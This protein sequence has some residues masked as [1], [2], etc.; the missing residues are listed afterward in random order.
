MGQN[1]VGFNYTLHKYLLK[2]NN[3]GTRTTFTDVHNVKRVKI[4]SFFWYVFSSIRTEYEDLLHKSPY[5]VRI[6]KNTD[7]KKLRIQ[8]LFTEWLLCIYLK[9]EGYHKTS[10][11]T[12][13]VKLSQFALMLKR[14]S[15]I[16]RFKFAKV[17]WRLDKEVDANQF[18]TI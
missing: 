16:T 5:S 6:K 1:I 14:V 3:K 11:I 9:L 17:Y 18:S 7:K 10:K 15:Y 12:K 13:R 4:R 8:T 2:V